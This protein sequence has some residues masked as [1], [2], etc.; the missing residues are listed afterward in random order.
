MRSPCRADEFR[1]GASH[2]LYYSLHLGFVFPQS[3]GYGVRRLS[4]GLLPVSLNQL[5]GQVVKGTPEVVDRVPSDE[6]DVRRRRFD[7]RH[8]EDQLSRLWIALRADSIRVGVE[9]G[10]GCGLQVLD[11]LFGP[12][13]LP[14]DLAQPV[15]R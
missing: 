3:L 11:V 4:V 2:L 15:G 6:Q 9:E 13:G 12:F 10:P 8:V 5:P 1:R 14:S 7:A